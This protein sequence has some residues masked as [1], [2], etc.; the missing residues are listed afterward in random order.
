[1]IVECKQYAKVS[2]KNFLEAVVDYAVNSGSAR[3]ILVN[4]S[5]MDEDRLRSNVPMQL[6]PEWSR[7]SDR[8]TLIG[9]FRPA[10]SDARR[11]FRDCIVS[12]ISV[13]FDREED[14]S[15]QLQS[16]S[17]RSP[18]WRFSLHWDDPDI[19]LDLHLVL[20]IASGRPNRIFHGSL[21]TISAAPWVW[22]ERDVRNGGGDPEVLRL[23]SLFEGRY[24]LWGHNF[25][26]HDRFPRST[27]IRLMI[28]D[29]LIELRP[30][31]AAGSAWHI[32]DLDGASGMM[33]I[34]NAI[35]PVLPFS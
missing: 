33:T 13:R 1:M 10:A 6:R 18:E 9:G 22:L 32:L 27:L 2:R 19:D 16:R 23:A 21:G 28:D 25:T 5:D 17:Q 26:K 4:Y 29:Q 15:R 34:V 35:G 20:P 14:L 30:P 24:E 31:D 8:V 7:V 11:R 12:Q 3:V